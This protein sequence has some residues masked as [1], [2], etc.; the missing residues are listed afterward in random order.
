[1]PRK[2]T[3]EEFIK[4]S[5]DIHD[6]RYDYSKTVYPK[7]SRSKQK[8]IVTCKEHGDFLVS[9]KSHLFKKSGC[10]ECDDSP[11]YTQRK[12]IEK[13]HK[14]HGERFDLSNVR[15][16]GYN[17]TIE[18]ICNI[19]GP[20]NTLIKT[21]VQHKCGC[22]FCVEP[23]GERAIADILSYKN[24]NFERQVRY[25]TCRDK[26]VLSFDFF[27]PSL[28]VLIERQGIQHYQFFP[29]KGKRSF[30]KNWDNFES[31]VRRD[32]IKREWAKANGY[33]LLVIPFW[34]KTYEDIEWFLSENL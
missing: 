23:F 16:T 8:I 27:I 11:Y 29:P 18:V 12:L 10:I 2:L 22:P 31:Q 19:H 28:N 21:F 33:R 7:N 14:V 1:M 17:K 4:R 3:N 32:K 24:I 5:N 30:H 34:Y 15:Y 13:I 25:P 6:N 9:V 20:F 26:N